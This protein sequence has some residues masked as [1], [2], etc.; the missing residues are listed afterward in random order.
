MLNILTLLN[1][2]VRVTRQVNL[3][4]FTIEPGMWVQVDN[5][6]VVSNITT[7]TAPA[8][9][10]LCIT[11]VTGNTYE[12]HDVK[13]GHITTMETIGCRYEVSNVGFTGGYLS[14]GAYLT[15]D[16]TAGNKG[17]LRYALG[18]ERVVAVV[19][20]YDSGAGLLTCMIVSPILKGAQSSPSASES[21][22]ASTS[23]SSST[24]ASVSPSASTSPSSSASAS[25]SPSASTSP[26]SSTSA[27]VSPSASKS[28]SS[29]ASR[30]I[31]P[32]GSVSPSASAS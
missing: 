25:V 8:T 18:G 20:K 31:S 4:G 19:E 5:D 14:K 15:V 21:P 2:T 29:S 12:S 32:S 7:G 13:V 24:S 6:G 3:S 30:S 16:T 27:S 1:K 23:P 9:A 28:P 10:K 26:S 11:P 17:K 22:S